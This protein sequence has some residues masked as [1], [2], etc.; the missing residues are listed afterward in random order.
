MTDQGSLSIISPSS[1][2]CGQIDATP[3]DIPSRSGN[4]CFLSG[5]KNGQAYGYAAGSVAA[6]VVSLILFH[7]FHDEGEF[8]R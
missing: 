6:P 3:V 7:A 2:G 1:S 5:R 4:A 8:C